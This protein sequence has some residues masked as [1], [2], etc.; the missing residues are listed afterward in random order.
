MN[1]P[2]RELDIVRRPL[3]KRKHPLSSDVAEAIFRIV[4][5]GRDLPIAISKMDLVE[6]LIDIA[7]EAE[8]G[9]QLQPVT[10]ARQAMLDSWY[11]RLSNTA[12]FQ[13]GYK[14]YEGRDE[15]GNFPLVPVTDYF[16]KVIYGNGDVTAVLDAMTMHEVKNSLP[17]RR[18]RVPDGEDYVR[19]EENNIVNFGELAGIVVFP[20]N[21]RALL[22]RSWLERRISTAVGQIEKTTAAIEH[23][24]PGTAAVGVMKE[25]F[26]GLRSAAHRALPRPKTT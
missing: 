26:G 11:N 9:T 4:G 18:G 15:Y 23:V 6:K 19:D 12:V 16:F 22:L 8:D 1:D 5:T 2:N 13:S 14:H 20:R 3:R 10:G 24:R 25:Q 7:H 17:K 21:S